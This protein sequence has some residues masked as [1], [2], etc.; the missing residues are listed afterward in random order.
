[1]IDPAYQEIISW[2]LTM[3]AVEDGASVGQIERLKGDLTRLKD[4]LE[5]LW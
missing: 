4:K 3:V 2:H 5:L 1:M